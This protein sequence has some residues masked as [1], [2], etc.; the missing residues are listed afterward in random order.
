MTLRTAWHDTLF[1][2]RALATVGLEKLATGIVFNPTDASMRADPYPFYRRLRESD[3]MHR[4][5][6]GGGWVLSR[7][8]DIKSVLAD[9]SYSADERNWSLA[10]SF[11][12]R[13]AAH[14]VPDF[15]ESGLITMLR[16]DPPDHTR[17]RKLVSKA[18]TPRAIESLRG[19]AEE[20][21]DE[22]LSGRGRHGRLELVAD[23]AAPFPIIM[24]AEMLGVPAEDRDRFRYWSDEAVKTLG[25]NSLEEAKEGLAAMEE[26]GDYIEA[27]ANDRRAEPRDD[28]LS[29]LVAAEEEGDR[30]SMSELRA[31]CVLLM[32]AGNE[33]TTS[34]IGNAVLALLAH[35]EQAA[36]LREEPKRIAGAVDELLRYDSPV[37]LTSRIATRDAELHGQRVRAGQQMVLLLGSANRDPDA[38][39]RPDELDVTRDAGHHLSFSFGLHRCLGAQLAKLEGELAVNALLSRFPELKLGDSPDRAIEWGTNTIL[40]GPKRLELVH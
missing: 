36:M 2:T 24:I 27:V 38:F 22:L 34:L 8:D 1:T 37:Q 30:L 9:K 10:R 35:P 11:R 5:W 26:F 32:V 6:V 23:L 7:Y 21:L 25:D 12:A 31:T 39:D 28:L 33:T 19:R 4:S 16:S 3:P 40:R 13:A 29:G 20:I 17:V 18:F 15:Y 14:G